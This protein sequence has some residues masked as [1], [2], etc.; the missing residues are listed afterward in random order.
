MRTFAPIAMSA[1]SAMSFARVGRVLERHSNRRSSAITVLT[2]HKEHVRKL[3]V[4][5]AISTMSGGKSRPH[6]DL[7]RRRE[8]SVKFSFSSEQEEFRS[9]LRRLLADRSPTKEVRRLMETDQGYER[10]S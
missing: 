2:A 3:G 6:L 7:T 5:K 10:D 8:S 1:F 9:N 4:D